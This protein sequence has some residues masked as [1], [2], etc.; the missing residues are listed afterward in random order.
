[1]MRLLPIILL[2]VA[3]KKAQYADTS[4]PV[5]EEIPTVSSEDTGQQ[6]TPLD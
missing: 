1:M 2:S 6:N 5:E 4:V 3:C